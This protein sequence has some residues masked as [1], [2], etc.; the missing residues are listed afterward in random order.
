MKTSLKREVFFVFTT[1]S[2]IINNQK[3]KTK[4]LWKE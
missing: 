1:D 3:S 2:S 4:D